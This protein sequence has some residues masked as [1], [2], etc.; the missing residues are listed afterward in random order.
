MLAMRERSQKVILVLMVQFQCNVGKIIQHNTFAD[1]QDP[2]QQTS[3]RED[4][5]C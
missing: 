2:V 3:A 4:I 5:V 1:L